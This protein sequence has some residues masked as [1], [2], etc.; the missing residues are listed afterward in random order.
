MSSFLRDFPKP[1]APT[2]RTAVLSLTSGN[3]AS[4]LGQVIELRSTRRVAELKVVL[5]L[6]EPVSDGPAQVLHTAITNLLEEDSQ[7]LCD[8]TVYTIACETRD[9]KSIAIP[10]LPLALNYGFCRRLS[11]V[12]FNN[13]VLPRETVAALTAAPNL[14]CIHFIKT[15]AQVLPEEAGQFSMVLRSLFFEQIA[16]H[17]LVQFFMASLASY[18]EV[19]VHY[20]PVRA[21]IGNMFGPEQ[22]RALFASALRGVDSLSIA[23]ADIVEQC[24]IWRELS[25]CLGPEEL[26]LDNVSFAIPSYAEF[27]NYVLQEGKRLFSLRMRNSMD[28]IPEEKKRD[29]FLAIQKSLVHW[30]TLVN[31][32]PNDAVLLSEYLPQMGLQMVHLEILS[33]GEQSELVAMRKAIMEA[34][35]K[36]ITIGAILQEGLYLLSEELGLFGLTVRGAGEHSGCDKCNDYG[37]D[38]FDSAEEH[39]LRDLAERNSAFQL[40]RYGVLRRSGSQPEAQTATAFAVARNL[41]FSNNADS[42][43]RSDDDSACWDNSPNPEFQYWHGVR[44]RKHSGEE[45][46]KLP[47]NDQTSS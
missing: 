10:V 26:R 23:N 44:A 40:E 24:P 17:E 31:I 27:T 30:L 33:T 16:Q 3:L 6:G 5:P 39:E 1:K 4:A 47:A 46:C 36:D 13:V 9:G 12:T 28:H 29:L 14:E 32:T 20:E 41:E 35:R 18:G 43:D 8:M 37:F 11:K 15:S 34:A 2:P 21:I 45:D 22:W 38:I 7:F 19:L 25:V 42:T